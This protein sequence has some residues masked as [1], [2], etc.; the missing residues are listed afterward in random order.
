MNSSL[1]CRN[2]S[3][4]FWWNIDVKACSINA[5]GKKSAF[6]FLQSHATNSR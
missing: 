3:W 5:A 6:V 4:N 2:A 1:F